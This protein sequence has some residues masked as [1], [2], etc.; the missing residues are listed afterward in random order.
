MFSTIAKVVEVQFLPYYSS[1][2]PG[3]KQILTNAL[4]PELSNL[5][6]RAMECVS[7]IG[8][9][10]GV[11]DFAGDALEIMNILLRAIVS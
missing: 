4:T 3:V 9:A 8:E 7:L 6:G 1:F 11:V 2:M 5:R 10:V